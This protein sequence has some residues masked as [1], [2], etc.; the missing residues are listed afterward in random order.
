MQELDDISLLRE[1][2]EGRKGKRSK[3]REFGEMEGH[4]R[5]DQLVPL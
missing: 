4:R 2:R 5:A 1:G 3:P